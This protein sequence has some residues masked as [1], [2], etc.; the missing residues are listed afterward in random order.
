VESNE[1]FQLLPRNL[2]SNFVEIRILEDAK[3]RECNSEALL[4]QRRASVLLPNI[5][6]KW[7]AVLLREIDL[8]RR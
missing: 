8:E 3:L 1:V 7:Q 2:E 5:H 6:E 4:D